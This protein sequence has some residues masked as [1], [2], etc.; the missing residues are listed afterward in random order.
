[1]NDKRL[2]ACANFFTE[3]RFQ[4]RRN[5]TRSNK[6]LHLIRRHVGLNTCKKNLLLAVRHVHSRANTIEWTIWIFEIR[7]HADDLK[8]RAGSIA[9][10]NPLAER[11]FVAPIPAGETAIHYSD[12]RRSLA[13]S[14]CEVAAAL[15]RDSDGPKEVGRNHVVSGPSGKVT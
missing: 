15:D 10:A 7:R 11:L 8:I 2:I 13:V 5:Y 9:K 3:R 6:K 14:G 1:M 4:P 12:G